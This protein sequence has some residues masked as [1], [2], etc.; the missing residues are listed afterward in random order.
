M[1]FDNVFYFKRINS[2]GGV[3][4]FFYY[5]SCLYKNFTIIYREGHPDQVK[6]LA[7]NV[8]VLKYKDEYGTIKCNKFFCNYGL[9]IPVEA[10]E[11]YH[12]I[13][14]DYKQVNFSP[15]MYPGFKYIGVSKLACDSFKELTGITAELIYNPVAITKTGV[16][17]LTDKIHLISATR[18]T[19]EKGGERIN[20]LARLLDKAGVNYVWDIYTNRQYRWDSKNIVWQQP[21]LDLTKEIE[22]STYL[23]QLSDHESFGL[24]VAESLI[25]GTPV[26]ITDLPAF[27]EIGCRH[28]INAV[29]CDLD[30]RSV[31]VPLI[32]KGVPAFKYVPPKSNWDKYLSKVGTY[33][34]KDTV[35]VR[36]LR[37][38]YDM[39][40]NEQ[41]DYNK[42][43]ENKITKARASELECK[44]IVERIW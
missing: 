5:L 10:K 34:P 27:K 17:K 42:V 1:E 8:E 43:I 41:F 12:I 7:Q 24:S 16:P 15:I 3:E 21:K 11:K 36:T 44:G 33:N 9:D 40:L 18:L 6:R 4:S 13:H 35:P 2:I 32:Q 37:R 28:G 31:D 38:Y 29:V 14:C 23:V 22:Q 39:D 30:M 19:K 26:I 20:K 25:L